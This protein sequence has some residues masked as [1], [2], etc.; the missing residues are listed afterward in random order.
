TLAGGA[1]L[2]SSLFLCG[3]LRL[4][5]RYEREA[6]PYTLSLSVNGRSGFGDALLEE[7]S[8]GGSELAVIHRRVAARFHPLTVGVIQ[9]MLD[10]PH[11]GLKLAE[12]L[13]EF[14]L[15]IAR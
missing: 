5:R 10:Y 2:T 13:E 8:H 6:D 11:A 15:G 14:P 4:L 7:S 12:V 1:T 3:Q 9:L